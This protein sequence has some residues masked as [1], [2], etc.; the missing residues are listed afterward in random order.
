M[1]KLDSTG[2]TTGD[3]NT[4]ELRAA[5]RLPFSGH[6]ASPSYHTSHWD[7][8]LDC[9]EDTWREDL[10]PGFRWR[11]P[12][13]ERLMLPRS[14]STPGIATEEDTSLVLIEEAVVAGSCLELSF[15]HLATLVPVEASKTRVNGVSGVASV[16][17]VLVE[18]TAFLKPD[19]PR[20]C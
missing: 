17:Q 19:Q 3:G 7:G 5:L 2:V 15:Q 4:H 11:N 1:L 14:W 8:A 13:S 6:K 18:T 12:S 16:A 10:R 9:E 20:S